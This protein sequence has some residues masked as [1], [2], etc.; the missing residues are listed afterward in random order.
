MTMASVD[1]TA[2]KVVPPT[3]RP[4]DVAQHD[5]R[6]ND[7]LPAAGGHKVRLLVFTSLYPNS[8]QPRHGLF[9]EGRLRR[10]VDSGR[11]T[12]TV[13]AP[14][15][16]FPF[17]HPMF[18]AYSTFASVPKEEE[19]HGI[20]IVHPRFPVIPKLGMNVAPF[21]MYRALLPLLRK[22]QTGGKD[23][24]LIDA[25]YFY[26]DGVAAARLGTA[27]GKPVVI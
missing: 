2:G 16:W 20:R 21:L 24:D 19:R 10:L 22:L 4:S 12:A 25:H 14:V 11:I 17:R 6:A 7:R 27:I 5:V 8:A 15:P 26:P 1:R 23:F 9:I 3:T 13:V 18:G